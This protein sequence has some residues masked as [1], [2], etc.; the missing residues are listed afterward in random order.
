MTLA[1]FQ[2]YPNPLAAHVLSIDVLSR[3]ID[4]QGRLH[5]TR[6]LL[7]TGGSA[8]PSWLQSLIKS[9]EAYVLEV[10]MVDPR[11]ETME[12]HTY[13]LSHRRFMSVEEI[14]KFTKSPEDNSWTLI[15]THA[16]FHCRMGRWTGLASRIEGLGVNKFGEHLKKS[17][18][19]LMYVVERIRNSS[20]SGPTSPPDLTPRF[21][22]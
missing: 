9:R 6:L 4:E 21:A 16:K 8:V 17:R 11:G 18:Q 10:S 2:K 1:L 22:S 12:T 14:Q 13:N 19:A 15:E 3:H 5:S 7:K 20:R